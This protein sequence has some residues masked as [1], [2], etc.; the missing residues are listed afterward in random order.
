MLNTWKRDLQY[1]LHKGPYLCASCDNVLFSS[2]ENYFIRNVWPDLLGAKTK[3]AHER[4]LKFLVSLGYRYA[5]HFLAT[6]PIPS[7]A[8][9]SVY[10]RDLLKPALQDCSQIG[11][12]VFIYPYVH[13]PILEGCG[14]LHGVNHLLTLGVNAQNLLH[15]DGLPNAI[16]VMIPNVLLL[17]CDGDLATFKGNEMRSPEA[18]VPGRRFDAK[19]ANTDMPQFMNIVLNRWI[20]Q[21]QAHQKSLGRW[22]LTHGSDELL[23]PHKICYISTEQ[24]RRLLKWQWTHC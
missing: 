19:R 20:G 17:F 5:L 6:S 4:S 9:D 13:Q 16:V 3:W 12:S 8:A 11:T 2:W 7:N 22:K 10:I 18:L 1:D 14:L 15:E 24:D 23:N 21:G